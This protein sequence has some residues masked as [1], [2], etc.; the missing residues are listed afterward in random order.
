MVTTQ[1]ISNLVTIA[2]DHKHGNSC[3][4]LKNELIFFIDWSIW[5]NLFQHFLLQTELLSHQNIMMMTDTFVKV[6]QVKIS[7]SEKN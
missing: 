4:R 5:C 3:K 2:K 6:K 7:Q 1:L